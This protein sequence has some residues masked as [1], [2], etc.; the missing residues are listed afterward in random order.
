MELIFEKTT[1][2][3]FTYNI[4]ANARHVKI[5]F[6][7]GNGGVAYMSQY[8][9]GSGGRGEKVTVFGDIVGDLAGKTISGYVGATA[10]SSTGTGGAG[11]PA[12]TNGQH[13]TRGGSS[14]YGGGGGGCTSV[15]IDGTVYRASGGGGA[16][17][18]E[19]YNGWYHTVGGTGGGP[20]G[21][22]PGTSVNQRVTTNGQNATGNDI[23]ETNYGYIRVYINAQ[24]D[25]LYDKRTAGTFSFTIPNT[26][27][28]A[29]IE[30]AAGNGSNGGGYGYA[31]P[32]G[33]FY[34]TG[35][36]GAVKIIT[37]ANANGKTVTGFV[38]Q[39][40][41][42]SGLAYQGGTPDGS[43]GQRKTSS[44]PIAGSYGGGGGGSSYCVV[45][46]VTYTVSG[47]AGAAAH[48]ANTAWAQGGAGG[49]PNAG[50]PVTNSDGGDATDGDKLNTD[51]VAYIKIYKA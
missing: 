21:G 2:G 46:N 36:R 44:Q 43:D 28:T 38:G 18:N 31:P 49:G 30:I 7:G 34:G 47:G 9:F 37:I 12:G 35:G 26:V 1:S 40:G 42:V 8:S 14:F 50:Q 29:I 48:N 16:T 27:S 13:T 10:T 11:D 6:A 20:N 39:T 25:V 32:S 23:N 24:E 3:S 17:I 5:E 45:D 15:D 19:N 4:P 41:G 51:T 33:N 22:A